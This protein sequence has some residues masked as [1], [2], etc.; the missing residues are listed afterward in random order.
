MAPRP[1]S[2]VRWHIWRVLGVFYGP[3]PQPWH[4]KPACGACILRACST[5]RRPLRGRP[6]RTLVR[7]FA[8]SQLCPTPAM[9]S[10][11]I[12][13]PERRPVPR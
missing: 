9:Q 12:S 11:Y 1:R 8:R 5:A 3:R 2:E 10:R 4:R 6:A 7:A 13:L